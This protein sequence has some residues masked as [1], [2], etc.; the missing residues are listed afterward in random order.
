L[1]EIRNSIL[2]SFADV[3]DGKAPKI[4][5]DQASKYAIAF[6]RFSARKQVLTY[7]H[8]AYEMLCEEYMNAI[9]AAC[10]RGEK[11]TLLSE[12]RVTRSMMDKV[13]TRLTNEVLG[14][15]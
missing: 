5:P 13:L 12:L 7:M 9:Q 11:E 14:N 8:E 15:E 4:T 3:L 2:E 1:S 10:G 6:E